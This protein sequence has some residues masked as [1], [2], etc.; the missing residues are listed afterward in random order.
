MPPS[1]IIDVHERAEF[2]WRRLALRVLVQMAVYRRV[3]AVTE[4]DLT[5]AEPGGST[6]VE[7]KQGNCTHP[8]SERT[9]KGSNAFAK[10]ISCG[11][12][13]LL[14]FYNGGPVFPNHKKGNRN[15][16]PMQSAAAKPRAWRSTSEREERDPEPVRNSSSNGLAD[17]A[18]AGQLLS[19]V[20]ALQQQAQNFQVREAEKLAEQR[21]RRC[22]SS[23]CGR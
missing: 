19:S 16:A 3:S 1:R 10:R 6:S 2:A 13:G 12:C 4:I 17:N 18:L 20:H 9:G 15:N 23:R 11:G 21:E 14:L 8:R 22:A 5:I 7:E